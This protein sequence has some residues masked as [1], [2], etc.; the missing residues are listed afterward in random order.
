MS[1]IT[2][3]E[4]FAAAALSGLLACPDVQG[5]HTEIA[6]SAC[7]FAEALEKAIDER[8]RAPRPPPPATSI[9]G[10]GRLPG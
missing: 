6:E 8:P 1:Q 9:P 3:F 5:T 7:A 2:R 10:P 4:A